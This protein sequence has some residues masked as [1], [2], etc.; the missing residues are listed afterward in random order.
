[1]TAIR[2]PPLR[3]SAK[4]YDHKQSGWLHYLLHFLVLPAAAFGLTH[5]EEDPLAAVLFYVLAAVFELIAVSFA[6]LRVRDR[7]DHLRVSFGPLPLFRKRIPYDRITRVDEARSSLL[8][9]WGIHWVPGRGW[10]WNIRGFDCVELEVNGKRMR[11]GTDDRAGLADFVR[12]RAGLAA[13]APA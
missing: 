1:M 5:Q 8:D 3:R 13:A 7:G 10:T 11:I 4:G 9:G 2:R 12:E 6:H